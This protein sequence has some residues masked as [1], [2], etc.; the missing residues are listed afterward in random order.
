VKP[1]SLGTSISKILDAGVV[2]ERIS[3]YSRSIK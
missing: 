2:K 3:R 1:L